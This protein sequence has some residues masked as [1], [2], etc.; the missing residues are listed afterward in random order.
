MRD[1]LLLLA[2]GAFLPALTLAQ[3]PDWP[4]INDEAM[5]HFQALV[6]IDSTDPPGNETKVAEYVKGVRERHRKEDQA[7]LRGY[8]AL[9][10]GHTVIDLPHVISLG[11]VFEDNGLPR[12]AVATSSHIDVHVSRTP[13]GRVSF[14]PD[15]RHRVNDRR[16][17]DC[18]RLPE[19]T[20]PERRRDTV[21][22]NP[23]RRWDHPWDGDYRA[24][25]PHVPPSLL[26]AFELSGY[27]TLFE[28]DKWERDPKVP[29]V[30]TN[31]CDQTGAPAP[32][33]LANS[34]LNM[35]LR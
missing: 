13:D 14:L 11:G 15:S 22:P 35:R 5:R 1:R 19:A 30:S 6:Q 33:S 16:M 32:A 34:A 28:V 29:A 17:K 12:L 26:P 4:K 10:K 31:W 27:A 25:V 23:V 3:T 2:L 21:P 20:L 7:I 8:R 24:L 9:A 18:F